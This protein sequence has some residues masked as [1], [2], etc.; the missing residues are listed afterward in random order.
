MLNETLQESKKKETEIEVFGLQPALLE[1]ESCA[2][3]KLA[4]NLSCS[5]FI[6]TNTRLLI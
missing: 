4:I 5:S 1:C 2:L 6:Q 3:E